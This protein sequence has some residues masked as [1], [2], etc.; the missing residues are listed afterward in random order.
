M[1]IMM[2]LSKIHITYQTRYKIQNRISIIFLIYIFYN[3]KKGPLASG[4][5]LMDDCLSSV[6]SKFSEMSTYY[7]YN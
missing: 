5:R 1:T 2:Y 7:F 3:R 6:P 4:G